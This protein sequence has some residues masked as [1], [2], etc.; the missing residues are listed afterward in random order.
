MSKI[1]VTTNI[2]LLIFVYTCKQMTQ[3]EFKEFSKS[4]VFHSKAV[5]I[6]VSKSFNF[7]T[8]LYLLNSRLCWFRKREILD[9]RTLLHFRHFTPLLQKIYRN[10]IPENF[11]LTEISD[12]LCYFFLWNFS[13]FTILLLSIMYVNI[14]LI[15]G[16][17]QINLCENEL[18]EK[19]VF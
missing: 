15:L 3:S 1:C 16:Y 10:Q 17:H 9:I 7:N 2:S 6:I 11:L 12:I 19:Y 13:F 4:G 18:M 14:I 8:T 5:T